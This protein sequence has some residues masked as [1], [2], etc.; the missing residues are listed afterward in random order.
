MIAYILIL[1][2][3]YCIIFELCAPGTMLPCAFG[4][5]VLALGL[6]NLRPVPASYAGVALV[7]AGLGLVLAEMH[8]PA[9]GGLAACGLVSFIGGSLLLMDP[10]RTGLAPTVPV[11]A[12]AA[13]L[14][15]LFVTTIVRAASKAR[16]APPAGGVYDLVGS[17]GEVRADLAPVGQVLVGGEWW[18]AMSDEP[19]AAGTRVEVLGARGL[20]LIVMR[21]V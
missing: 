11:I 7:V 21:A 20:T 15:T 13:G 2:G 12:A 8:M 4:M 3:L 6:F 18:K 19:L 1:L 9:H 17:R 14:T 5:L 16:R 10:A